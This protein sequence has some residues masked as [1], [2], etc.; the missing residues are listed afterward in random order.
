MTHYIIHTHIH[1]HMYKCI[2]IYVCVMHI[3]KSL[4]IHAYTAY[5]IAY[6]HVWGYSIHNWLIRC[7]LPTCDRLVIFPQIVNHRS[8]KSSNLWNPKKM[9][10]VW[11]GNINHW[12]VEIVPSNQSI[13]WV[14][15]PSTTNL[16]VC[17]NRIALG[18][19]KI[20]WFI[21]EWYTLFLMAIWMVYPIFRQTQIPRHS[22]SHVRHSEWLYPIISRKKHP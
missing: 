21:N 22:T 13:I 15:G 18:Y 19:P 2:Y 16:D 3:R 17:E 1:T 11:T 9:E 20:Q 10:Q 14:L 6:S 5:T 7:L 12:I 8:T 4:H